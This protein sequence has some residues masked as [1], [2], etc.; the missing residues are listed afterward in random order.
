MFS[1]VLFIAG[2]LFIALTVQIFATPVTPSPHS[3]LVDYPNGVPDQGRAESQ[4]FYVSNGP[5]VEHI[6]LGPA[7]VGSQ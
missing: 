4:E 1:N 5:L 3:G 6:L 7:G 2:V